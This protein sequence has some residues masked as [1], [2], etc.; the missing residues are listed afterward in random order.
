MLVYW[1]MFAFPALLTIV[2]GPR[3]GERNDLN[4]VALGIVFISFA[5]LIGLRFEVGA[6]WFNYEYIVNAVALED[7]RT[8][9][10]FGDP[11]FNLIAWVATRIGADVYGPN[12]VCGIV[13]VTGLIHFCRRQEN[14]WLAISAAVPYLVIVVG[15]GYVRQAAA[16]GFIL[17]ALTRFERG[18]FG[19]CLG[20]IAMAALFHASAILVAPLIGLAIVRKQI[21]LII[22]VGIVSVIMFIVLLQSRVDAAYANYVEAEYDSS[23]AL[24]RLLMNGVPA[25]LYVL[26]R[27]NFPGSPWVKTLWT[28]FAAM[29][30]ALIAA[31]A[32]SPST[33]LVDRIGLYLIP[34]QIYVFGNLALAMRL[35]GRS[36]AAVSSLALGY[37]A[38]ILFVWLNFANHAALW[39]PYRF[40]PFEA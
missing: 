24:V 9:M 35:D 37:Y 32:V 39:I 38:A 2:T 40:Y 20:W 10:S 11:G 16:I 29:S 30:L 12:L 18:A 15:M 13:L 26:F 19:R 28:L 27:K 34:I 31:V 21:L 3:S 6:D 4:K 7:A 5:L 8:A 22:P 33:T 14:I 1:L 23:G 17:I 25:L 36:G